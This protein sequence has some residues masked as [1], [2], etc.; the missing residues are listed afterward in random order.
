[1]P[2]KKD[3]MLFEVHPTPAKGKDGRNLLYVRPASGRKLTFRQ[4]DAYCAK[5]YGLREFELERAFHAFLE[6]TGYWLAEGYRIETPIGSFAPRLMLTGEFT[7][8]EA[9]DGKFVRLDN[10]DYNPGQLWNHE[11]SKWCRGFRRANNPNTQEL[12]ANQEQLE[13]V[14]YR[15]LERYHG[16][17]TVGMF[18]YHSGLT[19][20]SAR[21]QLNRWTEGENPK[22]LKT[23]RGK[24][25][26]YTET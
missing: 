6:A 4:L 10:V 15:A 12:L 23:R 18:A 8:P 26:I 2:T 1:M 17:V 11:M 9:V 3:G 13:T 19:K 21:K 22:L 16:Y 7:D 14:L 25:D 5:H 24:E 20:Y